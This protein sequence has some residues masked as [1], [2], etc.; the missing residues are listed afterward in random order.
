[1]VSRREGE[2]SAEARLSPSARRLDAAL[3]NSFTSEKEIDVKRDRD[4]QV[5]ELQINQLR[6]SLKNT[7]D[8][9]GVEQNIAAKEKEQ[10]E[11]RARYAEYKKRFAELKGLPPPATTPAPAPAAAA[12]SPQKK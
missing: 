9:K 11:I 6:M 12:G 3:V 5:V 7:A 8:R 4:L 2:A 1:M 10:S